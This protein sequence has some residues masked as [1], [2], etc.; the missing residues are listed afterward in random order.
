MYETDILQQIDELDVSKLQAE[1]TR[2]KLFETIPSHVA[3]IARDE[4]AYELASAASLGE[5]VDLEQISA[6]I[7]LGRTA[8]TTAIDLAIQS[9]KRVERASHEQRVLREQLFPVTP[10]QD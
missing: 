4:T 2:D 10:L 9:A 8:L 6:D 1:I 7:T 5:H 3:A